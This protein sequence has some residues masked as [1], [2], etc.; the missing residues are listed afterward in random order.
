M[1]FEDKNNFLEAFTDD[2]K[3]ILR[4][5]VVG[6]ILATDMADHLSHINV[7]DSKIKHKNIIKESNNGYLIIDES[8]DTSVFQS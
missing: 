8:D 4:K 5:R 7:L 2:E 6:M 3:K 1:L